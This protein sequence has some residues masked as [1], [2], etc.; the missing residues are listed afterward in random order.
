MRVT[1]HT[2]WNFIEARSSRWVA[3]YGFAYVDIASLDG[4]EPVPG[5]HSEPEYR[6][7]RA[8]EALSDAV[9]RYRRQ[10]LGEE[11]ALAA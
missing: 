7:T 2:F 1:K 5:P 8:R 9:R 10:S 3:D 4:V 6:V 11:R